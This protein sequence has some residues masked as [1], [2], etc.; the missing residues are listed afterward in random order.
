MTTTPNPA[1]FVSTET[2]TGF[3]EEICLHLHFE[4][5]VHRTPASIALVFEGRT[6]TYQELNRRA[7]QL[8]HYLRKQGV[9]PETLVAMSVERSPEMIVGVLGIMK[10]GGAYLPL[11]PAYPAAR[12]DYIL[13]DTRASLLL[14]QQR[15][16]AK[17]ASV[18]IE[19]LC[20]DTDWAFIQQE[21][22]ENPVNK[23]TSRN[24]AYVIYTSGS[25]GR[26]KGVLIEQRSACN[27]AHAQIQAF[28]IQADSRVLQFASFSF[29]ASVSEIFT[30]LLSGARLYLASQSALLPGPD[31]LQTLRNQAI[32]TV[33][34]PPSVFAALSPEALPHLKTV[35]SAGETCTAEVVARWAP[36][37]CFLNAYGPT[38][39]TVCATLTECTAD[40]QEPPIGLPLNNQRVYLLDPQLQPM[41]PGEPGEIYIGGVGVARGYRNRPELTAEKFMPN[42]FSQEPGARL[43]RTGDRAYQLPDGKFMFIGRHDDQVK[44]RGFRIEL[45]EVEVAL[46]RHP[47][48]QQAVAVVQLHEPSGKRLVAYGVTRDQQKIALRDL[49]NFL[50]ETLPEYMLPTAWIQL[51]ALPLTSNGKVDR[52]ALPLPDK[53]EVDLRETFEAPRTPIEEALA[54]IWAEVLGSKQANDEWLIGVNDSFFDLGGH[55]LLATQVVSRM[56]SLFQVDVPLSLL[57]AVTPTVA[58]MSRTVEQ[59]LIEQAETENI[60]RV[61]QELRDIPEEGVSALLAQAG[62][63]ALSWR[64]A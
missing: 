15:V 51:E 2:Q 45:G 44:V 54:R 46:N 36:A 16:A 38:E 8:A 43:Y 42:P 33:T 7:N 53:A 64:A 49:R 27:L 62:Q 41:P 60:R 39:S 55:S 17:F 48:V 10:A 21:S 23:S 19:R 18:Q 34:L 37:R 40:G 32:T 11:D 3:H 58:E 12:L 5:Q 56:S 25:T 1:R 14:T 59:H 4:Q 35:I 24:L 31:L 57:L 20:L 28:H 13:N 50:K 63:A 29:D 26:P 61:I 47:A 52:Q 22:S 9:G 6:F 30:A